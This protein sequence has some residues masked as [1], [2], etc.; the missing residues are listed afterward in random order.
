MWC[1]GELDSLKKMKRLGE[2]KRRV[3]QKFPALIEG[4]SGWMRAVSVQLK[5]VR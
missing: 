2:A 5:K 4:S 1:F 3:R